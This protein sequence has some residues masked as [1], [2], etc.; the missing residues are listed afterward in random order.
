MMDIALITAGQ[1]YRYYLRQVVVGDGR[2]PAR[3]PLDRA[4]EEVGVP[5]GGWMGRGLAVLGL[6]A[7]G[8]VTEAQLRNLFGEGRHPHA[9]RIEAD[10]LA[11]GKKP[12]AARR[13]G[14][15]GRR[16]KVTGVD[17][18]FRPQPTLTLLWALGD[19]ETR[20]AIEAAH[21]RVIAAC[22]TE[23]EHEYVTAVDDDGTP[24]F[25]PVVCEQA[26]AKLN[27]IATKMTRPPKQKARPL[28]QLRAWWKASAI[29]TSGVAA[30]VIN[31]LLEHA[32]AA[33]AA[34]RARVTAAVD[35]ALAAV[36]VAATVFVMNSGGRFHR[37]HLLTEARRHL[38]LAQRGR[39]REPSLD[40]SIVNEVLAAHCA[41]ITK[42]R[43]ERGEE[44]GYRLYT[45]RW[46]PAPP[47]SRTPAAASGW[48]RRPA[49]NPAGPFLPLQPGE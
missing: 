47:R 34:I 29:L 46:A 18:T 20:R 37:R 1:M 15:L 17:L 48:D 33:A 13:A 9:D 36:D 43:T 10:Q 22:L 32:R 49:A 35:V 6:A 19:E 11:A 45:A 24:R 31:S 23:L 3:T 38:A 28:A 16:V 4:Q 21:E 25:L 26:R 27:R 44:S 5:A 14:A 41:D 2:R 12:A 39:R 8:V 42:A 30:D 7:G 40:E